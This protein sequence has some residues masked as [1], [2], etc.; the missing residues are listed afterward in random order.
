MPSRSHLHLLLCIP[1]N[2]CQ[3]SPLTLGIR[4]SLVLWGAGKVPGAEIPRAD[5]PRPYQ[6]QGQWEKQSQDSRVLVSL[7]S[8][9]FWN[10]D[11]ALFISEVLPPASSCRVGTRALTGWGGAAGTAKTN[12]AVF[13]AYRALLFP[14]LQKSMLQP[15]SPRAQS[16]HGKESPTLSF[17]ASEHTPH[18]QKELRTSPEGRRAGG[19]SNKPPLPLL[20]EAMWH[21]G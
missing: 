12:W 10:K 5:S 16:T 7:G 1:A 20:P 6:R 9:I 19:L 8:E 21:E 17:C 2:W 11:W 18:H 4:S 3:D 14:A 15:S 13:S